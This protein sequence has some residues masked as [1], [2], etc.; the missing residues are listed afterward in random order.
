LRIEQKEGTSMLQAFGAF[1]LPFIRTALVASLVLAGIHAYLGFHV[2]RRGVIFVDLA[3]AQ[4]A[5]LG[6]AVGLVLGVHEN[7]ILSY[8]LA[9]SMTLVGAACFAWLRGQERQVPLEAFIGIVFA[10]AQAMVFL[11]LEKSPSGPEHLKETLVGALFTISPDK[12]AKTAIL[13]AL[14][15]AVH[16]VL[17]K[18]FFEITNDPRGAHRRGRRIFWWDFLFY[19]LFGFVVTSSVQI[20]GVL[21]VFG[22]LV[23]PSVAGLLA[24]GRTGVALAVGWIFGFIGSLIGVIGSVRFDLPAA[25]S[26]LVA[27][28]IL[29]VVFGIARRALVRGERTIAGSNPAGNLAIG[30]RSSLGSA[31]S[32]HN[33]CDIIER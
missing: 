28:A 11:V 1:G 23:I 16:F 18:P 15:G 2:V 20:A 7:P 25:P 8:L 9:L 29:L 10:T 19:G 17:R 21:L 22:F 3:L 24:S 14:I 31:T 26:I 27:L 32:N 30:G 13:Y 6:V 33:S 5:A 4:M 12:V